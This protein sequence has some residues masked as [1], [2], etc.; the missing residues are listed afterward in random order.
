MLYEEKSSVFYLFFQVMLL[1]GGSFHNQNE[2]SQEETVSNEN[3]TY[4][5]YKNTPLN[6]TDLGECFYIT[7]YTSKKNSIRTKQL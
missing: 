4:W 1:I 3:D 7:L 5:L 2:P 6:F